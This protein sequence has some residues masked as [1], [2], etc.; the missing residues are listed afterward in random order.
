MKI[1]INP[2]EFH[3]MNVKDIVTSKLNVPLT[4][5]NRRKAWLCPGLMKT[6]QKEKW[7]M[8]MLRMSLL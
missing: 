6:T 7:K 5:R 1:A 4:S 2:R 3:V 8:N